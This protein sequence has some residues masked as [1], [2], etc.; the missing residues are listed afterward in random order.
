MGTER[1]MDRSYIRSL[2]ERN[3][4]QHLRAQVSREALIANY[5]AQ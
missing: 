4:E 1:I 2:L 3:L 5:L